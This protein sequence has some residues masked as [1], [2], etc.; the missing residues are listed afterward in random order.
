M[1]VAV[2]LEQSWHR[3]PGGTAVAA[4]KVSRALA[5]LD[6]S[7]RPD[8]VGVSARHRR[9]APPA[10]AP[11]IPVRQ[12]AVPRLALYELWSH[13]NLL[14]VEMATGRVDLVHATTIVP[15]ASRA[16]L[17]VTVHDLA[18]LHEP[19]MFTA[20]GRR[21]FIRCLRQIIQ[22]TALVLCSSSTT[23][24]DCVSAGIPV[25]RL[26][27]VLLGV[28]DAPASAD[29]IARVRSR[30]SLDRPF[31]VF[32]GTMEPRKNLP[33]LLDA[34]A[35]SAS[36]ID[37]DLVLVGPAGWGEVVRPPGAVASRVR[38]LGFLPEAD[39]R[40]VVAAADAC[41]L[42]SL[43][44]GFGLPVLE[45][46]AQGTP[47][48]TSAGT[49]TEEAAGG[50]AVLVDPLDVESIAHGI[51]DALARHDELAVLGRRRAAELTWAATA[52]ATLAAY[53]EL[54]R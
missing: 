38:L 33:R 2:T 27:L 46:M 37:H 44:E 25:D 19:T 9:P 4:L 36:T 18:F 34:F 20:H 1:R 8:Q 41:C 21:L 51:T 32:T 45:A 13:G 16:P 30:Y 48:V 35:R 22:R 5:D 23:M 53:R 31:L 42:P 29:E 11:S 39:R 12:L 49:S 26:R 24:R 54:A 3:V 43:R 47:V 40:A 10:W 52:Q 14:P 6:P 7:E 15:A 50:A 28:D 17:V